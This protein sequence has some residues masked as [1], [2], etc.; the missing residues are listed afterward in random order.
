MKAKPR[1]TYFP[2]RWIEAIESGQQVSDGALAFNLD[3]DLRFSTKALES[4]SF[5]RWEPL[6]SDALVVAA[7]IEHAD[8]NVHRPT[9]GWARKLNLQIPVHDPARWNAPEVLTSLTDAVS[10]V[11]GDFWRFH[12]V[13]RQKASPAPSTSFLDLGGTTKAI[14]AFSDGMDS[15]AVAGIV[16]SELGANLV[17]V[18]VGSKTIDRPTNAQ[19]RQPFTSVPY[20]LKGDA[21]N[22][23]TSART[24]G[25]KFA[26]VTAIAAYLTDAN[27]I[28]MPES[29]QGAIGPALLTV[30]HTYPDYRNHP[31]F[32]NRMA[33]FVKAILRKDVRYVFPRIWHTKGE[34]LKEFVRL[35]GDNSWATTKSCWRGSQWSSVNGKLRQCG[36]CAAC[37]LRRLSVHAAGLEERK[38]T[39][40]CSDI[41]APTLEKSVQEGF[42]KFDGVFEHYAI[43]GVLHMDHLADMANA[44]ALTVVSRH[45]KL[46]GPALGLSAIDAE[47]QLGAL[48]SR[49]A[50][51]WKEFVESIGAQSFIRKWVK[52]DS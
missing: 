40:I 10:F 19:G 12:F 30:A 26:F 24:R 6:I 13:P 35:T 45:A 51:E 50:T 3:E 16:G 41:R 1:Q 52:D 21:K 39:Y 5:A 2:E 9:R 44:E 25:F 23:E 33:R 32:T 34:T 8:K 4:Y 47:K 28:V 38:D 29:G 17:R 43:A 37:M 15:R 7:T 48:L 11:S 36:V 22:K 42:K 27:E 18:R 46:L 49:H 20:S 14:I 31:L